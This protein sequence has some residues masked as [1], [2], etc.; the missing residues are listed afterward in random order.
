MMGSDTSGRSS[1]PPESGYSREDIRRALWQITLAWIFGAPF[2]SLV[3]GAAFTS[4]LTKYLKASDLVYGLVMAAGPAAMIFLFFGSY[5]AEH[6]GRAKRNMVVFVMAH[7]AIWSIVAAIPLYM[8]GLSQGTRLAIVGLVAFVS[9]ALANYGG[10]GWYAWIAEIVPQRIAGRFFG[11]RAKLAMLSMGLVSTSSVYLLQKHSGQGW[12]YAL[13]FGIAALLGST[14]LMIISTVRETRRA[15]EPQPPTLGD[16]MIMPWRNIAFRRFVLYTASASIAYTMMGPFA[17]RFCF[18]P[19]RDHGLGMSVLPAHLLLFILPTAA[20][21]WSSPF[22]GRAIDRYGPKPVLAASALS[23]VMIP[24]IWVWAHHD[25]VWA[26]WMASLLT[27]LTWPGIDQVNTWMMIKGFPDVRRTTYTA[28][29]QFVVGLATVVGTALGG[30]CASLSSSLLG[31]AGPGWMSHYQPMF[32]LTIVLR[33]AAFMLFMPRLELGGE[34]R[35]A[36]VARTIAADMRESLPV[37]I[38]KGH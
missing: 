3:G 16:V 14:D 8:T 19:V 30:V 27:G 33:L 22:W 10:G 13:I 15:V 23:A 24:T 20:M 1:Q 35:F 31:H 34:A 38:K 12:V 17:W 26:A 37:R 36:A 28:T 7:R 21:A 18:E 32:L 2:F 11:V 29:F 6:S 9:Q 5:A 4:F 25:I